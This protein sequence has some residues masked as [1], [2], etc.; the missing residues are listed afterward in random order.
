[1]KEFQIFTYFTFREKGGEREKH[2]LVAS[3]MRPDRGP[4]PRTGNRTSN[5]SLCKMLPDPL[6]HTSPGQVGDFDIGGY[7]GA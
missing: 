3:H 6:S 7:F 1:M 4:N 2:R 5:L